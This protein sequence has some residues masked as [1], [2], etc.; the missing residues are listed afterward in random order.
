VLDAPPHYTPERCEK[1]RSL[2]ARA[3]E[4]GIRIIPIASSG[5]DKE[6]EFLLRLLDIY[7]GGTYLFL[8]DDS[9]IG[10]A[11]LKPT[12]GQYNVEY[13]NGL[14]VKVMARYLAVD[15]LSADEGKGMELH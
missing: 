5:V 6:T 9:G 11:H 13:L 4:K 12:V 7:T 10:G 1:I 14:M 3:A 8:T 15:A 2:A